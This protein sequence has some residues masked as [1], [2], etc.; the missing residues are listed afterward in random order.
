VIQYCG[1]RRLLESLKDANHILQVVQKGLS[2]F[3]ETK[4]ITFPRLY[5]LSDDELLGALLRGQV[6]IACSQAFGTAGVEQAIKKS[7]LAQFQEEVVIVNLDALKSL[8]KGSLSFLQREILSALIVIEVHSRDV[9]Q[10]LVDLNINSPNDFD[11]I[12]QLR[13]YWVEQQMKVRAVNAEF[14]YGYEYLGN[15]GRLKAQQAR[16]DRFLFEGS[17]IMLKESCAVFITMNPGSI[18]EQNPCN[19]LRVTGLQDMRAGPNFQ[20]T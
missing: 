19:C 9:T 7:K 13:Y 6:V 20:T 1:D 4:R 12:S 3:L 18:E 10:N 16:L 14:S 5:F 2:E 15:S 11:W 8:V 17:E